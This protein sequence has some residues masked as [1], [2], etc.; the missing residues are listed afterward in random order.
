MSER[1][2]SVP[3]LGH[4]N[5]LSGGKG[6]QPGS[7]GWGVPRFAWIL[8]SVLHLP[9]CRLKA[10]M[11][12]DCRG[13]WGGGYLRGEKFYHLGVR[14]LVDLIKIRGERHL[15]EGVVSGDRFSELR[16]LSIIGDQ[17]THVTEIFKFD[18]APVCEPVAVVA[19]LVGDLFGALPPVVVGY[20][21]ARAGVLGP[22]FE[23]VQGEPVSDELLGEVESVR[24]ALKL[25]WG[26]ALKDRPEG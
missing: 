13:C 4:R 23:L 12:A 24:C 5:L 7:S 3:Q 6:R 20:G 9:H 16:L 21:L 8:D 18:R 25:T 15:E 22:V 10:T 1:S 2:C 11:L 19:K 14:G 26:Y 17:Q